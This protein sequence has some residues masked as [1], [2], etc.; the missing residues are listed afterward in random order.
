MRGRS[1]PAA[2]AVSL[3]RV[4]AGCAM[5]VAADATVAAVALVA[6]AAAIRAR[7]AA[8]LAAA[9][10]VARVDAMPAH[11]VQRAD[12]EH[13]SGTSDATLWEA[14]NAINGCVYG[15]RTKGVRE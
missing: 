7:A 15:G 2:V 10:A 9:A 6:D 5:L 8:P 11:T 3:V 4:G 13:R 12:L 1:Q 14:V